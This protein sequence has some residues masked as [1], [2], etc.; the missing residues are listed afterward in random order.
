[1]KKREDI[2]KKLQAKLR[3]QDV[4]REDEKKRRADGLWVARKKLQR[5]WDEKSV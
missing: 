2:E 4:E 3:M 5:A 1:M